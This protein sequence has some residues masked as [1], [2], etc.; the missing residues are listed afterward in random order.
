MMFLLQVFFISQPNLEIHNFVKIIKTVKSKVLSSLCFGISKS[1]QTVFFFFKYAFGLLTSAILQHMQPY[2]NSNVFALFE[3]HVEMHVFFFQYYK[4]LK[5]N[6][7]VFFFDEDSETRECSLFKER[8]E[9]I[10]VS[11]A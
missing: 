9:T 1:R 3:M 10:A 2:F 5:R 11:G 8:Q 4:S 6:V 7:N